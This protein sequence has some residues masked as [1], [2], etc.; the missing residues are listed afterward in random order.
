VRGNKE[1]LDR[2]RVPDSV[3][4]LSRGFAT[5][6]HRACCTCPYAVTIESSLPC[7]K[8][9][10][11]ECE[12]SEHGASAD[13]QLLR[14]GCGGK[15]MNVT[16]GWLFAEGIPA[17]G[18]AVM[19]ASLPTIP[20]PSETGSVDPYSIGVILA[21]RLKMRVLAL[22]FIKHHA[23]VLAPSPMSDPSH[24][25]SSRPAYSSHSRLHGKEP[26][27]QERCLNSPVRHSTHSVSCDR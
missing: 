26:F 21:P 24:R 1:S 19:T 8:L 13:N 23:M 4:A 3:P 18:I 10:S 5:S 9:H 14:I 7:F 12:V 25:W 15:G 16:C 6:V 27:R 20:I 11:S 2:S 17:S 22:D